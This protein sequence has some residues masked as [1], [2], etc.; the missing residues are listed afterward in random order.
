MESFNCP[1]CGYLITDN[2]SFCKMCGCK[3]ERPSV[4]SND[5]NVPPNEK[6]SEGSI[7]NGQQTVT[8]NS[9]GQTVTVDA[10]TSHFPDSFQV[11]S[12]VPPSNSN[13]PVNNPMN[14]PVN[15][16]VNTPMNRPVNTPVNTP[17]NRPVNTPVNNPMNRP[18]N[19]PVNN[20]MNYPGQYPINH[21]G[22]YQG[23][24]PGNYPGQYS[25]VGRS[26]A[27]HP[28]PKKNSSGKSTWIIVS[29]VIGGFVLL[30]ILSF[31]IVNVTGP[32]RKYNSACNALEAQRFDEAYDEFTALGDYKD[33]KT[34]ATEA[35]YQKGV[36]LSKHEKYKEA[37]EIFQGLGDYNDSREQY[38]SAYYN[39]GLQLMGNGEYFDAI[40]VF[41]SLGDYN[42]SQTMV[43]EAKYGYIINHLDNND[44]TTYSYLN[45]LISVRY[46]DCQSIYRSLYAW[47]ATH[48]YFNTDSEST[49]K[50]YSISKSSPLYCHFTIEGGP[51]D[52]TFYAYATALWPDGSSMKK[53]K[54]AVVMYNKGTYW[55]GWKNGIYNKNPQ[56]GKTGTFTLILYDENS[57]EIGRSSVK[58][59]Q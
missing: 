1:E 47:K 48:F 27:Y 26:T 53:Q 55:W 30:V 18:V 3:I 34:K 49:A 19:T 35:I 51:P 25:A 7:N 24:Y 2:S 46:K 9:A 50:M 39:Y 12:T 38:Q 28:K 45:E 59:T 41:S 4:N 44:K 43:Y 16:P 10:T 11:Y 6:P 8:V 22:Q 32:G 54:S 15:T 56:E 17:M 36:Y 13:T 14:R 37:A 58:I 42:D 31:V 52:G 33:S 40:S 57:N 20:P 23:S 21:P 29:S 5:A